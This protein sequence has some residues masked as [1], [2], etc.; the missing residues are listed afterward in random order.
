MKKLSLLL[1]ILV[2]SNLC[3]A[4][5]FTW[6]KGNTAGNVPPVYGTMGVPSPANNPGARHGCGRWVDASGNLWLF[7]G[8]GLD[9]GGTLG[10]LN[11]L[12]KYDI[13]TNQWTWIRGANTLDSFGAYGT[14]GVS[15]A[16]NE[17][18]AREFMM[19]WTDA[20]GNFWMFGGDGFGAP[21]AQTG[22][23]R[24]G[25]L[26]KYNPVTNQWTWMK[27][28]TATDQNGVYGTLG[29]AAP[30][31]M[32]GGRFSAGS[33]IDGAGNLW[34][35]GGDGF[36]ASGLSDK[37]NDLWKYTVSTNEWTWVSGSNLINQYGV[38]G[39]IGVPSGANV[40][41]S[42]YFTH[43]WTDAANNLYM[44]GGS[45]NAT[46]TTG[47]LNDLWKFN[48]V[49]GT[50]TWVNGSSGVNPQAVY[51]TQMVPSPGTSPGGRYGAAYWTDASGNFYVFG[52]FGLVAGPITA[53]ISDLFKYDPTANM[54]TY[55]KG[56][57]LTNQNGTYG[58]MGLS[59]PTNIPGAR[60][61]NTAW[62]N[63]L[64]GKLWLYGGEG[65]DAASSTA[66]QNLG[67]L[68][69]FKI[70]CNPDSISINPGKV[71]CSG[72]PATLIAVNG[73]QSTVW[74]PTATS[75][76]SISGGQQLS[77]PVFT[78]GATPTTYS[79]YAEA[80]NCTSAPRTAISI[81]VNPKPILTLTA[82]T[83]TVCVGQSATLTASGAQDYYWITVSSTS[84]TPI[85][86]VSP[87][88]S[89]VSFPVIGVDINGCRDTA[90]V[91][92]YVNPLPNVN[93]QASQTVICNMETAILT[94]TG[95]GS[96]TWNVTPAKVSATLEVFPLGTSTD[97]YTVTGTD[98]N[99]CT[100]SSTVAI[101]SVICSGF[102]ESTARG[103]SLSLYPNPAQNEFVLEL[104]NEFTQA[105]L[106]LYNALGQKV[107]EQGLSSEKTKI[108]PNLS[109]GVYFYEVNLDGSGK[110]SGKL[111]M[112]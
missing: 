91:V 12:W 14:M 83:P 87:A 97:I 36:P 15:S 29:I 105:S 18:G 67:D 32:P 75:T 56:P 13:V 95:A 26:W 44:F 60:T 71:L 61:Y 35:F 5:D 11:D 58:T 43:G 89:T 103:V 42:R 99:G 104:H 74:F 28:F 55:M 16:T 39:T 65:Y 88:V 7:G 6:V 78:T 34:L 108:K 48:P 1:A 70:P 2:L 40:P 109:K 82:L 22:S 98:L 46:S 41:G 3:V 21:S 38:Y 27:G 51:G 52:G 31:N 47:R 79:Y 72:S 53:R 20:S 4:Q 24:L 19:T 63:A 90:M 10:W 9:P 84:S 59:A 17:P 30:T 100:K 23:E 54:W 110:T 94:A 111:I 8:E 93:I 96:Y 57:Q 80:N 102:A 66:N 50:W 107:F 112:E 77:I 86:V 106:S 81:T 62:L 73:G 45:G 37:L 92:Q 69:F 68:W 33:W 76:S 64:S 101:K 85:H 49:A 25:D